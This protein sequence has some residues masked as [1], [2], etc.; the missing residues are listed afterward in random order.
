MKRLHAITTEEVARMILGEDIIFPNEITKA[1]GLSYADADLRRFM[2]TIPS[3][4][5]LR[6][7]KVNGYAVVAGPPTPMGLLEV[8]SLK[9][10]HFYSENGGWYE[11]YTFSSYDKAESKWLAIRKKSVPSSLDKKWNYQLR[12][13]TKDEQIPNAGEMGWFITTFFE[14]RSIRLFEQIYV[15]TS[16]VALNNGCV[17]VGF[18]VLGGLRVSDVKNTL[19]FDDLGLASSRGVL[20]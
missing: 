8:R 19:R 7:C 1:W 15:R 2:E 16:S 18:F 9:P 10:D 5:A 13:L 4:E 12:L 14:V 3:I 17:I 20:K 6:W 11:K